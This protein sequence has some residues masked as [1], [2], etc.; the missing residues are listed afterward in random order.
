MKTINSRSK[1]IFY[2]LRLNG[3]MLLAS[4]RPEGNQYAVC[5][6]GARIGEAKTVDK[7]L[8]LIFDS[9][10]KDLTERVQEGQ[11]AQEILTG[12][13]DNPKKLKQYRIKR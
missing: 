12:L 5:Y 6:R 4:M 7:G 2:N 1:I 3:E 10:K 9:L 8:V 11:R 13:G